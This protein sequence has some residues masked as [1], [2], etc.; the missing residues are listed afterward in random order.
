VESR[1]LS[2]AQHRFGEVGP[3]PV[4]QQEYDSVHVSSLCIEYEQLPL[5]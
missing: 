5:Y 3:E 4:Y 1:E 2:G